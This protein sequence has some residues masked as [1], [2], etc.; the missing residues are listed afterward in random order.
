MDFKQIESYI[1]G[2]FKKFEYREKIALFDLDG[3]IIKVKSKKKFSIN[4]NDWEFNSKNIITKLNEYYNNNYCIIIISNQKGILKNKPPMQNWKNKLNNI[5]IEINIPF[6][7]YASLNDDMY[8]KPRP[9]I[10]NLIK[11]NIKEIEDVFYC[12]DAYNCETCFSD[13]D[14]KFAINCG[15]KFIANTVLFDNKKFEEIKITYPNLNNKNDNNLNLITNKMII[16]MV[17]LPGSGKS[18]FVK[19][20]LEN[21]GYFRIN[22]D[23]L[24]TKKRCLTESEKLLKQN[25]NLVIDNTNPD[26]ISRKEYIDLAKKYNYNIECFN[27]TTD[28]KLSK[29]N[30]YYRNYKSLGLNKLIPTIAYNIYSKKYQEPDIL[31]GFDKIKKINFITPNDKDY[32]L[33][34]Y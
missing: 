31:E 4:E 1:Y 11:E 26:K 24:K 5:A 18:L 33:Y 25:L 10:Y 21:I 27:M 22:M 19:D 23:I 20:N 14:Y 8:R 16:M 30:N 29:H 17:G 32:Q 3:T 13:T 15:I 12:G 2:T 7:I 28:I 9:A 34:F 6:I